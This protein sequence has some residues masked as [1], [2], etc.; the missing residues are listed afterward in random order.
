MAKVDGLKIKRKYTNGPR[1]KPSKWWFII[2]GEESTL[3]QL[4]DGWSAVKYQTN[5]S[6][7]PVY[8]FAENP[9]SHQ[10]TMAAPTTSDTCAG[11]MHDPPSPTTQQ[12][13]ESSSATAGDNSPSTNATP[14]L[15]HHDQAVNSSESHVSNNNSECN[16]VIDGTSQEEHPGHGTDDDHE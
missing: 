12:D 2:H 13:N 7:E 5:W 9:S 15:E 6:L 14:E 1:N 10:P 8:T 11:H 4:T 3:K 16:Q